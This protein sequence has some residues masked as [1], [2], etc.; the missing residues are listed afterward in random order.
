ME[1]KP[2]HDITL[3]A[4][5]VYRLLQ[6]N[7]SGVIG[8]QALLEFRLC[9]P[10]RPGRVRNGVL[11]FQNA[12]CTVLATPNFRALIV[13]G[14][15]VLRHRRE[16]SL[17]LAAE[18]ALGLFVLIGVVVERAVTQLVGVVGGVISAELRIAPVPRSPAPTLGID[19]LVRAVC[20]D[21]I[22]EFISDVVRVSPNPHDADVVR[23]LRTLPEVDHDVSHD[24]VFVCP[25]TVTDYAHGV[26]GVGMD[27]NM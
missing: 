23:Y 2:G 4:A 17:R 20:R 7:L 3:Q 5:L 26:F 8:G 25:R 19:L 11:Q 1:I 15:I 14:V 22:R 10:A 18:G 21:A 27:D 16:V 9:F 12:W 13:I 6:C 24:F